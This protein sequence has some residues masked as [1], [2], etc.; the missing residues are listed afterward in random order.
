MK[1]LVRLKWDNVLTV[2]TFDNPT[3]KGRYWECTYFDTID[4][5][6]VGKPFVQVSTWENVLWVSK[7]EYKKNPQ[8]YQNIV[9]RW[10]EKYDCRKWLTW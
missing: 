3:D 5:D 8:K 1:G 10:R 2:D 6:K 7:T 9:K 4:K